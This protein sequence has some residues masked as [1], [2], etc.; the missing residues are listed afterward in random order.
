[1]AQAQELPG[2]EVKVMIHRLKALMEKVANVHKVRNFRR[3]QSNVK[4]KTKITA[5][6]NAF[7]TFTTTGQLSGREI[8]N[9]LK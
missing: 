6:K 7:N 4:C 5:I 1:M 9:H 8:N 2:G 3:K